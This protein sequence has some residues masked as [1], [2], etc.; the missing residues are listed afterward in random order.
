MD[1]MTFEGWGWLL[2][3]GV[4]T[5]LGFSMLARYSE[6]STRFGVAAILG[7]VAYWQP[8]LWWLGVLGLLQALILLFIHWRVIYGHPHLLRWLQV[9]IFT[10]ELRNHFAKLWLQWRGL[11]NLSLP[12]HPLRGDVQYLLQEPNMQ[13]LREALKGKAPLDSL[14]DLFSASPEQTFAASKRLK[15]NSGYW[16]GRAMFLQGQQNQDNGYLQMGAQRMISSLNVRED[17]FAW[18]LLDAEA[19]L[20]PY[21]LHIR[22]AYVSRVQ[23]TPATY[24]LLALL[25]LFFLWE[26]EM[27]AT[28]N[29]KALFELGGNLRAHTLET[30]EYWRLVTS[31]F[32]HA[33]WLHIGLNGFYLYQ[34]GREVERKI[35]PNALMFAFVVSGVV[36]SLASSFL[37]RGDAVSIGASGALFGLVALEYTVTRGNF[38]QRLRKFQA[39][40]GSLLAMLMIGFLI[41]NVDNWAHLG[42]L[43]TGLLLG[44]SYN[45]PNR[46]DQIIMAV[47]ASG[48]MLWGV[49]SLLVYRSNLV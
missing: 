13:A 6:A 47:I 27:G 48:V 33:S 15:L 19:L 40:L 43:V 44:F 25:I 8:Q 41:P 32:L 26:L 11:R 30:G 9:G 17:L 22:E 20:S 29:T 10:P 49:I 4:M 28:N 5:Y 45:R 24:T 18:K 7:F 34:I 36:G 1:G 39:N 42:G 23:S 38:A 3:S 2:V 46:T 31:V 35:G 14:T 16:I 12:E 37:G 21:G